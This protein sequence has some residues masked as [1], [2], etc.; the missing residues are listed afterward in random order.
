MWD[1]CRRYHLFMG[2]VHRS[3]GACSLCAGVLCCVFVF[4]SDFGKFHLH[5]TRGCLACGESI[6][7]LDTCIQRYDTIILVCYTLVGDSTTGII[8]QFLVLGSTVMPR[9]AYGS[10]WHSVYSSSFWLG[11][12]VWPVGLHAQLAGD[13]A[14]EGDLEGI[15]ALLG[16]CFLVICQA[17]CI[18]ECV[19]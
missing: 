6:Y 10:G 7:C 18:F 19:V 5:V 12:S 8:N 14:N 15:E 4:C 11:L 2:V 9:M 3:R 13:E 1:C 16:G 17:R